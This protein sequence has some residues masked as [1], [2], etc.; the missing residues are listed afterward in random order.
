MNAIV[1]SHNVPLMSEEGGHDGL[2]RVLIWFWDMLLDRPVLG[3]ED[4]AG[5]HFGTEPVPK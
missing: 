1:R 4:E 5:F 2:V 3:Y